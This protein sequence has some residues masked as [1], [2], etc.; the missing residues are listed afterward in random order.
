MVARRCQL[1]LDHGE[2]GAGV[3]EHTSEQ[4]VMFDQQNYPPIST[5]V[6]MI[7]LKKWTQRMEGRT[8]ITSPVDLDIEQFD[9]N[10]IIVPQ[11]LNDPH[12]SWKLMSVICHDG[13]TVDSGHYWTW[14]RCDKDDRNNRFMKMNDD[15]VP[16]V[17]DCKTFSDFKDAYILV[18]ERN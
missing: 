18:C 13:P 12:V 14:R 11:L 17:Q 10:Y 1:C 3:R 9:P 4:F 7:V 16:L 5:K 6:L 15:D 8:C 2:I